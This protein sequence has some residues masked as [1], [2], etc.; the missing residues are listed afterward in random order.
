MACI[1]VLV[2]DFFANF[3]LDVRS[4][5]DALLID[6]AKSSDPGRF[7]VYLLPC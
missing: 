6:E 5:R 1:V 4:S 3:A 2:K 7:L